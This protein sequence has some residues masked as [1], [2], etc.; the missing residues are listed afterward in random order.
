MVSLTMPFAIRWHWCQWH[1][2][3]TGIL[4]L[5]LIVLTKEMQWFHWR[6]HQ[7]HVMLTLAPMALH[8]WESHVTPHFNCLYLGNTLVLLMMLLAL[9]VARASDQKRHFAYPFSCLFL[10]KTRMPFMMLLALCDTDTDPNGLMWHQHQWYHIMPMPVAIVSWGKKS[11]VTSNFD[12]L[13]LRNVMETL[14]MLTALC[15]VNTSANGMTWPE[16][17]CYTS[18][19][20]LGHKECNDAIENAISIMW[21]WCWCPWCHMTKKVMSL[22]ILDVL[23]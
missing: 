9:C 2:M 8:D 5:I 4:Y 1:Y 10:R 17:S 13:D 21:C 20:S 11:H 22:F 12:C 19:C 3:K 14:R 15:D 6:C 16:K 7:H 23:T 18:L